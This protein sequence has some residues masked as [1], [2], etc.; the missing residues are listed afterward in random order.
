[1]PAGGRRRFATRL[2]VVLISGHGQ[3]DTQ[4]VPVKRCHV[5]LAGRN[6]VIADRQPLHR[7]VANSRQVAPRRRF[8]VVGMR[9]S[10]GNRFRDRACRPEA[11]WVG[12]TCAVLS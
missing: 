11:W 2:A 6:V 1:M 8:L 10:W 9:G 3:M 12:V 5:R 4:L 7:S